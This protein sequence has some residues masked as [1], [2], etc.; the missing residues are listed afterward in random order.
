[1]IDEKKFYAYLK[2]KHLKFTR[3]RREIYK[4]LVENPIHPTAN[5]V[6][7]AVKKE[8]PGISFATVYNVLNKFVE[9]GLIKELLIGKIKHF[10]GNA[11]PHL[12]LICKECGKIEDAEFPEY[13]EIIERIEK[14]G[15]TIM[16]ARFNIY[17]I[18]PMCSKKKKTP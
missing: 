9:I 2:R 15:W 11:K 14:K 7:K 1:M 5:A 3:T 13:N 6:Y 18:C 4:F 16:D 12:H 10:D 8:I 17:G